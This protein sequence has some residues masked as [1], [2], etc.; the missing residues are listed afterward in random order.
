MTFRVQFLLITEYAL[1]GNTFKF[2]KTMH[3]NC[4]GEDCADVFA[5]LSARSGVYKILLESKKLDVY[6]DMETDGGG[7]L[8]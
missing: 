2:I 5:N 1:P 4:L 3:L 8:V 7:W 6:C